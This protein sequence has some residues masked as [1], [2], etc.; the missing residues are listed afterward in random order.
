VISILCGGGEMD[1]KDLK[2]INNADKSTLKILFNG[3]VDTLKH[4]SFSKISS[5]IRFLPDV[6]RLSHLSYENRR[7][8]QCH[9]LKHH[10]MRPNRGE[11]Y[12]AIITEGVGSE[13]SGNH[14]VVIIQHQKGNIFGEKVNILPIEG[15]GNTITPAY[16]IQLNNTDLESGIL[17]KDPSR[18]ILTDITTL[19][20][21]RL[22]RKVGIVNPKKMKDISDKLK[23]QLGL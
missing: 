3:I 22:E 1:Y 17:D 2:T 18:I 4:I 15:D 14:L 12:N 20:K 23:S 7:L 10:P 6:C 13:L 21:A 8:R 9:P 5:T 19:D 16:Q 11:I